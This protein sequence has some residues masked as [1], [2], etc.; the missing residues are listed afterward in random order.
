MLFAL[1][2]CSRL[3]PKTLIAFPADSL[4][5]PF[6]TTPIVCSLFSLSSC[7]LDWMDYQITRADIL[8]SL[9]QHNID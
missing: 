7:G 6:L 2:F 8:R 5:H 9:V 1:T 3:N 4:L